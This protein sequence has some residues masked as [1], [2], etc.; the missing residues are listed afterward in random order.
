MRTVVGSVCRRPEARSLG[1]DAFASWRTIGLRIRT[2][3]VASASALML[4]LGDERIAEPGATLLYHAVRIPEVTQFT[5]HGWGNN[6]MPATGRKDD[7]EQVCSDLAESAHE[8]CSP[9]SR[10]ST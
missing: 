5:A 9:N 6:D 4:S 8:G 2:R 3:V 7:P 10:A 1:N